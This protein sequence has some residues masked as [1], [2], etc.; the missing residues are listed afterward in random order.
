MST[1]GNYP[2]ESGRK[3]SGA[4][5][6]AFPP[7]Y[8]LTCLPA[9]LPAAE[10]VNR[11][12]GKQEAAAR[13]PR[14]PDLLEGAR[15]L[16]YVQRARQ[17]RAAGH[18]WQE[19]T[20]ELS[21]P[22]T[23][24]WKWCRRCAS[25]K[26]PTAED[27]APRTASCGPK[28]RLHLTDKEE[29]AVR[30]KL[31]LSNRTATS[32]STPEAVKQ[33]IKD[34]ALRPELAAELLAREAAGKP[35]LTS[36][37]HARVQVTETAIRAF[38]SPRDAWLDY[39]QS[40]GSIHLTTDEETGEARMVRPGERFTID[41]GTINFVCCVPLERKG[42][43]CWEKHK[44]IIGRFQ[45][46]LVVDHRSYFIPGFSYTAR[47]RGS[48]RAEDITATLH[49]VF[50]EHGAPQQMILEQGISA[51]RIIHETLGALGVRIVH[52][53]SPHQKVVEFL[54]NKLWTKLSFVPGQVGRYRGEEAQVNA[55]IE[56]CRR[57]ATDPKKHFPMLAD[58]LQALRT[59]IAEHN[60]GW[61]NSDRYG[62]WIPQEFF[63]SESKDHLRRVAPQ[64]AWM[65]SPVVTEPLTVRGFQV[66][67][68]F[69]VMPGHSI[70]FVF[71]APFLSEF[72][73]EQ[74]KLFYNPFA[75]DVCAKVVL[76]KAVR[77]HR[78]GEV[79]GDADQIDAY[80]RFS[81]RAFGYGADPDI[82]L[83]ATKQNAQALRRVVE[84]IRP[85][86]KPGVETHE[87]R[88]GLGNAV[89]IDR[90]SR[91][92]EALTSLEHGTTRRREDESMGRRAEADDFLAR[93]AAR[94]AEVY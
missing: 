85:D 37:A 77:D 57:G 52:V 84:A 63:R 23:T 90:G 8:P 87:M 10:Q 25:I 49:N 76:A 14:H 29:A 34:G 9:H 6:E 68:T 54:F 53:K 73:G 56:S 81:R 3:N 35:I 72:H 51:A 48:Y 2:T 15:R 92:E 59:A 36:R 60:A 74:V 17:L 71:N 4:A 75:P 65:F 22:L 12:E 40:P 83:E 62:R 55:L 94:V 66:Q 16:A 32:G 82:G 86:G 13:P 88:D 61:V 39:V 20:A 5:Q 33:C 21:L 50:V 67:T 27:L 18:G 69:P 38:R 58:A 45:F 11:Y 43:P 70:K 93:R 1:H 7:A 42:D 30:S 44:V 19:V 41:D 64:D 91:R 89:R 78:A 47:P 80:A 24:L 79:L 28:P 46:L 26:A 31:L